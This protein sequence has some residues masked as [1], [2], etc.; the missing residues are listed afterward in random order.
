MNKYFLIISLFILSAS[1]VFAQ[2]NYLFKNESKIYDVKAQVENCDEDG[3]QSICNSKGVFYILKKGTSEVLQTIE[4]DETY[5]TISADK[6]KKGDVTELYG[7]EH[8]GVYFEDYNFDG[9]EDLGIANGN[10]RPYGGTSYDVFLY[11][12]TKRK[13]VRDEELSHLETE[14]V[15]TNINKKLKIIETET[16]SGCCWHERARYRFVGNR[17]QK[18]YVF[19]EDGTGASGKWVE[20]TTER[21]IKGKWRST[22]KR[23]LLKK[24]YKN[25]Y[26]N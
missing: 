25:P 26:S 5:L 18:F 6:R 10:Y 21:L 7:N 11:S 1:G 4:M 13:F 17:L 3:K 12:K 19:T 16:K 22:T 20:V 23:Y 2:E 15:S 9:I 8:D 14:I 24:Y